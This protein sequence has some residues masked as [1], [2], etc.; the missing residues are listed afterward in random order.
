MTRLSFSHQNIWQVLRVA[1]A[2]VR[3]TQ[4]LFTHLIIAMLALMLQPAFANQLDALDQAGR[5]IAAK[6]CPTPK[7]STKDEK[8]LHDESVTD[9]NITQKCPGVESKVVRS[10]LS[11]YKH[12]V[13]TFASVSKHDSRVPPAFQIGVL[14]SDIK[15]RLGKPEIEKTNAISYMYPI[16]T[17]VDQFTFLHDGTRVTGIQW[18]WYFD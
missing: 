18:E 11:Q 13:P 4:R 12:A 7:V 10:S 9:R 15:S 8:N 16:E 1:F 5:K 17:Q 14:I 2:F 3:T 6:P